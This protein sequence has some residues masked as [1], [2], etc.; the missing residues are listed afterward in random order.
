MKR[1]VVVALIAAA[2]LIGAA[3]A[4]RGRAAGWLH[5]ALPSMHGGR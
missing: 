4:M 1:S 3:V 5:S 2:V